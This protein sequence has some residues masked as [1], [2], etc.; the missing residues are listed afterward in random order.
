MQSLSLVCVDDGKKA[1]INMPK[2][3]VQLRKEV[4]KEDPTSQLDQTDSKSTSGGVLCTLGS[5]TLVPLFVGL[6][7]TNSSIPSHVRYSNNEVVE[8]IPSIVFEAKCLNIR[9]L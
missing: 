9:N 5:H 3:W 7:K 2:M 1:G 6:Q 8:A 4:K